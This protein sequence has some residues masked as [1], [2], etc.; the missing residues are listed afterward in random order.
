MLFTSLDEIAAFGS[1]AVRQDGDRVHIDNEGQARG[2]WIDRV[3]Y[4]AIFQ[5]DEALRDRCRWLI[6]TAGQE[7]GITLASIHDLYMAKGRGEYANVCVPAINIRT[8]TYDTVR[9]I[10]RSME[11]G[12][13]GPVIF[14]IARSEIGYTFQRPAEFGAAVMA[15]AIR[16]GY[17]GPLYIQGDHFQVNAKK[18]AADPEGEKD[19]VKGL[20]REAIAAGFYNIDVDTSTLVDLDQPTVQEQQRANFE[21]GAEL[22]RLIRDLE[23]EAVTVSIGG[24][25]GEVGGQNSTVE[26]LRVYMAGLAAAM[27]D[28]PSIS[29]I[30]VQ[31]GTS[32]GGVP[33]PDGSVAQVALDFDVLR[34]C[35]RASVEEFGIG[36]A[37][38]HG[39]STLPDEAFHKFAECDACEVHLATG[40][41]NQ[42][43]DG[44]LMPPKLKADIYAWLD[45]NLAS[46][47]KEGMT[48][49]QFHYKTRKQG[50]GPFKRQ[51]WDLPAEI[52]DGMM[53]QLQ[54]KFM[55]LFGQIGMN[56]TRALMDK[57][58]KPA[59]IDVPCP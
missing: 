21:V 17:K 43:Y 57:H 56:D 55:Y 58:V 7:M 45:A 38:Q 42:I 22:T 3:I 4:N 31:T 39:A 11:I 27:G 19:V 41:Q 9:A 10:F 54:E 46:T 59:R 1:G 48:T 49:E 24:E 32:H 23:P 40:F 14:E 6:R 30:S 33:L 52:R 16:A 34:E 5:D 13:V 35:S 2:P 28:R 29:K 15:G 53:G 12:G 50:F 20:I 25:I 18:Y 44:G 26:E 37:V 8:L 47:R 51:M 36:G